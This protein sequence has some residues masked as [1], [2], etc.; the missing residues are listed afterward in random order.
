MDSSLGEAPKSLDC[1]VHL[2]ASFCYLLRVDESD[3]FESS[4]QSKV[5]LGKKERRHTSGSLEILVGMNFSFLL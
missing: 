1:S 2:R 4:L 5:G 3:I